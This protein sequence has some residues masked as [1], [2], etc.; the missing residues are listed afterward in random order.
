MLTI[1]IKI[2]IVNYF[3]SHSLI[4][5]SLD[6]FPMLQRCY[7][8]QT[9]TEIFSHLNFFRHPCE[10]SKVYPTYDPS[11]SYLAKPN[12]AFWPPLSETP[13][14]PTNVKSPFS[15]SSISWKITRWSVTLG[16]NLN[17][18]SVFFFI[19]IFTSHKKIRNL[20]LL[21][22]KKSYNNFLLK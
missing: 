16:R 7:F 12:R 13:R 19:A 4:F 3:C 20:E 21:I 10:A 14:S 22:T 1:K 8:K 5:N 9:T 17:S 18:F 15:N 11:P 2:K 6:L